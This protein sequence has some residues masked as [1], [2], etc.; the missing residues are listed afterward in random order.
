MA[1]GWHHPRT[2]AD[3]WTENG[4]IINV[5]LFSC[6]SARCKRL[7]KRPLKPSAA[8]GRIRGPLHVIGAWCSLTR[9]VDTKGG[10]R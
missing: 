8:T 5:K 7:R 1:S 4:L 2:Q 9:C 3:A 6:G 10:K